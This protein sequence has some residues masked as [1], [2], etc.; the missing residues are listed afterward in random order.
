MGSDI[1][2]EN[3]LGSES[4]GDLGGEVLRVSTVILREIR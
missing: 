1:Q 3:V 4:K 2:I